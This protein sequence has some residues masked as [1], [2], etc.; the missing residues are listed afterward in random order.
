VEG[1][2]HGLVYQ[3]KNRILDLIVRY[4]SKAGL[5][6][7]AV[8]LIASSIG[9]VL[10]YLFHFFVSRLLG[11]VEY[12][13]FNS[14]LGLSVIIAVPAGI[15]QTVVTQYVSVS[16]A[17]DQLG[18]V[19][20]LFRN[21]FLYLSLAS[22]SIFGVMILASAPIAAFLN[23]SSAFPVV[24]MGSIFLFTGAATTVSATLQGLQR[25]HV[26][27]ATAIASPG[28]R[29]VA[30]VSMVAL[31]WGAAGALGASAVM[32]FFALILGFYFL[33]DI[34]RVQGD[35]PR[36][37]LRAVSKYTGVVFV[38]TLAFAILTNADIIV[39]KH[40][41]SVEEAGYYSAASVLGKTILFFPGTIAI[42]MFPKT[43]RRYA[44]GRTSVDLVRQSTLITFALCGTA[45]LVLAVFSSFAVQLLF[46]SQYAVSE[47][48]VGWYGATMGL[49]AL[50]Q[51]FLAYYISQEEPRFVWLLA[52]A[53]I[54]LV[55][56]FAVIHD[57]LLLVILLL[58]IA[59][60]A[61][62]VASEVWLGGL[63]LFRAR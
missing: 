36:L 39:I 55:G 6:Q 46:G 63:G 16:F 8:L 48:L 47:S 38:G 14:L 34:W 13:A 21:A 17:R 25:F 35:R 59:A 32:S 42:V 28:I 3:V 62:L 2:D 19:S 1:I 37:S 43:A 53:A 10:Q 27:A 15:M 5:E 7:G 23:V 9:N 58:A 54:V 61:V 44:L 49:Y 52:A 22:A 57:S 18:Q 4:R 29:I 51:V 50:V 31:G 30:G 12:G 40:F 33:R 24:A 20:G 45:A 60:F 11:P 26:L 41:F 56:L